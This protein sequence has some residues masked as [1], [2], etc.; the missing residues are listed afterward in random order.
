[1][2][3]VKT[4]DSTLRDVSK[5]MSSMAAE[6]KQLQKG[7][8]TTESTSDPYDRRDYFVDALSR[9]ISTEDLE[10]NL[11][12]RYQEEAY[13]KGEE[14]EDVYQLIEHFRRFSL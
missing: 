14:L 7:K 10:W 4:E 9:Y 5:F 12:L 2:N 13:E 11:A 3:T 1:M 8:L 6:I